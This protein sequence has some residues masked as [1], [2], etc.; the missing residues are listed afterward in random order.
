MALKDLFKLK[1]NKAEID[2]DKNAD[3]L[4]ENIGEAV[5]EEVSKQAEEYTAEKP[6]PLKERLVKTK[7]GFFTKLKEVFTGKPI[8]DE[9]YE[10]LEDLL[11]QS[12][13]GFDMTLRVIEELE[14]RVKKA[15]VKDSEEVYEILKQILREKISSENS[16]LDIV[17]GKLNIILVVGVNGVGKTTSIGKI[18]SKLKQKNK[19]V[20]IGAADTFRAA[21]IEQLE[22]WGKRTGVEV[23]KQS[24]GSDPGAVVFDTISTA[25]SKKY[26]VA[27]IDTAG[28]LHNKSDLMKELEKINKIIIQQSGEDNFEKLLVIDSTTGQNGLQQAK[29]FN[30]IVDLSGVILTKFDGTAKGGIIFAIS[31]ELKKP[32][33]YLGVG[34]GIEDLREFNADEFVNAIFD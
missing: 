20:I 3:A 22:E 14:E 24:H 12:D 1:K 21:A 30:E 10:E 5:S 34:E 25:R 17:D 29:L 31:D 18:A 27:I 11:I 2:E 8:D 13:L 19:K 32:I 28:R 9:M 7:K 15:K 6:K 16:A 26:D 23:I 33:K 4:E